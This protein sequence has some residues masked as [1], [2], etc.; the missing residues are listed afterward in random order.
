M[1]SLDREIKRMMEDLRE[2]GKEE[3]YVAKEAYPGTYIQIGK[4]STIL[5]NLT[6]G[7]FKIELGELNV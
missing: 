7:R 1:E 4:K 6:C 5:S 2:S 3:I